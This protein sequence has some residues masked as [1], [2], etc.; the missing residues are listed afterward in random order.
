MIN[1]ATKLLITPIFS[2][3]V[4]SLNISSAYAI[5]FK[6]ATATAEEVE[7]HLQETIPAP[8]YQKDAASQ[9]MAF[10]TDQG[11][12]AGW[13]GDRNQFIAIGS[14][15]FDSED[16][17]YDKSYIVKRTLKTFEATISKISNY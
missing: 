10:V 1:R 5:E 12:G 9:A 17:S 16:P 11:L 2:L 6:A 3:V 8:Q 7:S 14:A 13:N 4:L 15:S